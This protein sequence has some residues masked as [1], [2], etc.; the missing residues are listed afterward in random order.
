MVVFD[1][2]ALNYEKN[3]ER[4]GLKRR[5]TII[6]LISYRFE[7]YIKGNT[8]REGRRD[9]WKVNLIVIPKTWKISF[10]F[11]CYLVRRRHIGDQNNKSY[12]GTKLDKQL[13]WDIIS[14]QL[15]VSH[16][17]RKVFLLLCTIRNW[18]QNK[19]DITK[20]FNNVMKAGCNQHYSPV[21]CILN[22]LFAT[23]FKSTKGRYDATTN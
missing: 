4:E 21:H 8:T 20:A 3:L 16:W 9:Q 11:I 19:R 1:Y 14:A 17:K 22:F 2:V 5:K 7:L 10:S 23:T 15:W 13:Y 18:L 6:T 12:F